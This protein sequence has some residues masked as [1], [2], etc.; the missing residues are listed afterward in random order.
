MNEETRKQVALARYRLISPVL[1]EPGRVQNEYFRNQAQKPHDLP[2]YG[3]RHVALS[4]FK[5]WLRLYRKNGFEGL[6]PKARTDMGRPR[7]MGPEHMAALRGKCK[8]Y[9]YWTVK[10]LYED[11]LAAGQ[12]GEPP[13]CYNTLLR[14]VQAEKLLPEPGR[15][16]VR[17][18][19]EHDEV[20]ELWVCDFMHGPLVQ[21]GRR[22]SKAILC[23]VIDDH[24]RMIVGWDFSVHETVGTL[25]VV[26]KEAMLAHGLPKRLYVD[27]GPAFSSDLLAHACA[28]ASVALIHSKPYDSPSRGKIERFFRTV[29]E[30]FLCGISDGIDI[31]ELREAFGV[32][33]RD[34]Y[35]Q[36]NHAG[37]DQRPI[38][39]YNASVARIDI[40]RLTR[41][42]L[43]EIFLVRHERVVGNDSTISFKGRIYEVPSAYIRQ[44]VELRHP[45]DDDAELFLYDSGARIA[46]LK[47]VDTGENARTFR[48]SHSDSAVSFAGKRVTP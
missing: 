46:R 16:D 19:F 30:R 36:R 48:P 34:D 17:K 43:D 1:A 31:D 37:I 45:V 21:A 15:K 38:D 20:G 39:R 12:L 6:M 40:R 23:A 18:R 44:R 28:L 41:A 4:T 25:T 11:L 5:R 8:A 47:L 2:H 24:S 22:S 42:E 9:P 10:R 14:T 32:W 3:V 13:V 35:H 7:R 26:L 27:N 29:R 33:L